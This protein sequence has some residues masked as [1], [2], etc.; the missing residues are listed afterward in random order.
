MDCAMKEKFP[1]F[2]LK[3]VRQINYIKNTKKFIF[4]HTSLSIE[5]V[6]PQTGWV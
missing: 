4:Y 5:L 1:F 2:A 3:L 6:Y